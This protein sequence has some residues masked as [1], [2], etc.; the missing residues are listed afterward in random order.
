MQKE[1]QK[2]DAPRRKWKTPFFGC[3]SDVYDRLESDTHFRALVDQ[4]E[5][6]LSEGWSTPSEL[7]EALIVAAT[8]HEYRTFRPLLVDPSEWCL[9]ESVLKAL[10]KKESS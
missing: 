4:L 9:E 8:R 1:V 3:R 7:R 10:G 2:I 6:L 5:Y